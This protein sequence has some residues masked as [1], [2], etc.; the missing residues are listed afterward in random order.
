M[1]NN[2]S[3]FYNFILYYYLD[4]NHHHLILLGLM[5]MHVDM[6]DEIPIQKN[7]I[8]Y[9]ISFEIM[10]NEIYLN[11]QVLQQNFFIHQE[12]H[13]IIIKINF[14]FHMVLLLLEE[15]LA[16]IYHQYIYN[17]IFLNLIIN[18]IMVMM[19][20]ENLK[21]KYVI[22]LLM[23][24]NSHFKIL[25]FMVFKYYFH[26]QNFM[27]FKKV[28]HPITFQIILIKLMLILLVMLKVNLV[29]FQNIL[30]LMIIIDLLINY[31]KLIF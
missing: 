27:S 18:Q 13:L 17:F 2:F 28:F 22:Y 24:L 26:N 10:I 20:N 3:L 15:I 21:M 30:L 6:V 23:I 14:S 7:Y 5:V 9:L 25:I 11:Q 4:M 8:I 12:K 16:F 1:V 19:Q 29:Y 31:P